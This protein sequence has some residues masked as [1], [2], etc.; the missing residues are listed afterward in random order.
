MTT[1]NLY[2]P[3]VLVTDNDDG[4]AM[5][6]ISL[7]EEDYKFDVWK[8]SDRA[9]VEFQEV[10]TW[11]GQVR[12]AQPNDEVY[13]SLMTSDEMTAFLERYNLDAVQRADPSPKVK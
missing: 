4:T 7:E 3:N 13:R 12:V 1:E 6:T 8:E 10:L 2:E 11:R 5:M 9:L